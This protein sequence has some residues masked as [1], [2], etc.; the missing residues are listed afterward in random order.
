MKCRRP[1]KVYKWLSF[2]SETISRFWRDFF[3]A[4]ST[5]VGS[6]YVPFYFV[7]SKEKL[8]W[9]IGRVGAVNGAVETRKKISKVPHRN[10]EK[11]V[12][13]ILYSVVVV[14]AY[15]DT[16]V[17]PTLDVCVCVSFFTWPSTPFHA[18][19]SLNIEGIVCFPLWAIVSRISKNWDYMLQ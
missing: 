2:S 15:I 18:I 11:N 12:A 19:S 8:I 16:V 9:I 1:A 4:L 3:A 7:S 5:F 6:S 17:Y 10:E 14:Y 13:R